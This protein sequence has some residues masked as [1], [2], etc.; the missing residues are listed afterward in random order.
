[1]GTLA[2]LL[3][4]GAQHALATMFNAPPAWVPDTL[5]YRRDYDWYKEH[6]G[7]EDTV[8]VSWDG[9]VLDDPGLDQFADELERLDAEL[10]ASGKPSLIQRVVTGPQLLDKLM[11]DW[12]EREYPAERA[13]QA[14]HGSF[15]GP[16]GRQSAALVVLS[17]IGGDDR[18]AMHDLILSAA[19]Q[20]TGLADDKIRLAGP[21]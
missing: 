21:P 10:V 12:T 15:I 6:F 14:L 8:L 9:A 20:A 5:P 13:R 7:T 19:T 3:V 4:W 17:E 16:D 1:M 18:P 2:P 11:S